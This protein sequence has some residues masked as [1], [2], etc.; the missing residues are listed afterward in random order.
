[1]GERLINN[2]EGC[3]NIPFHPTHL[4]VEAEAC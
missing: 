2:V 4:L 1:M 3:D